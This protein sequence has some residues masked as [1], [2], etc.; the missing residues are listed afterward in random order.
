M[1]FMTKAGNV[2]ERMKTPLAL[3]GLV[4]L[5]LYGIYYEILHLDIFANVGA[6]HTFALIGQITSYLFWLALLAIVL[7]ACGYFISFRG[8]QRP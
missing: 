7:A 2:L 6:E 3:A 5:V 1:E 4:V 8:K